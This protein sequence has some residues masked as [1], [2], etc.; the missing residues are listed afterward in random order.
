MTTNSRHLDLGCG[1]HP[2]NPYGCAEL[3]GVDLSPETEPN[4][5]QIRAGNLAI[6]QIP[7][8][9][10]YFDSVSAYDFLEHIPRVLTTADGRST[11]F[12]FIDL[13]NEIHRV[14]KPEGRFYASTP[15]YPKVQ[16]FSDPTHVNFITPDTHEYFTRRQSPTQMYELLGRMY[17]FHGDFTVLRIELISPDKDYHPARSD[18]WFKVERRFR[19][20]TRT[21]HFGRTHVLWEWVARKT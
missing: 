18:F 8:P 10:N 21:T 17:G 19:R 1:Q 16:A 15:F 3:F 4:S 11:R 6:D 9:D 5:Y 13:I 14:L 7:F 12:P 2:R 20:A